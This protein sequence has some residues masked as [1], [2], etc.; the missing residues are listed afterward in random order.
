MKYKHGCQVKEKNDVILVNGYR[1]WFIKVFVI[2]NRVMDISSSYSI[3]VA[4]L[5]N[6]LT[7]ADYINRPVAHNVYY[8]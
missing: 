8:V 5:K 4:Q 7:P 1:F 6:R 2:F 3:C